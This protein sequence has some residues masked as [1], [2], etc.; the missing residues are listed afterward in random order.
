MCSSLSSIVGTTSPLLFAHASKTLRT[1]SVHT[2]SAKPHLHG[3]CTQYRCTGPGFVVSHTS[4]IEGG[5]ST[6]F[7]THVSTG[8]GMSVVSEL[9]RSVQAAQNHSNRGRPKNKTKQNGAEKN[10]VR[11]ALQL[12]TNKASQT[13]KTSLLRIP[14]TY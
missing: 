7:S 10:A 11:I 6:H 1:S 9:S 14:S 4:M 5:C 8:A 2:P 3:M 12:A 13:N